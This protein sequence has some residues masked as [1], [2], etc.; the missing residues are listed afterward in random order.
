MKIPSLFYNI[1][2]Y[3]KLDKPEESLKNN[4]NH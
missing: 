2:S 3:E 1:C 4:H